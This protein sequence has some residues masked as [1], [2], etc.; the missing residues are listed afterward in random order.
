M[1][2]R[3]IHKSFGEKSKL[4]E[5]L[6]LNVQNYEK[7]QI[8]DWLKQ[9]KKIKLSNLGVEMS[10]LVA[11][12]F[13]AAQIAFHYKPRDTQQIAILLF[14]DSILFNGSG[15]LANISTGEGKSLVTISTAIAFIAL[16]GGNVDILTSSEIL[17]ERDAIESAK[18][19]NLFDISVSNN[20][21]WDASANE[22]VRKER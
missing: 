18:M 3:D 13:R 4:F 5:I 20:C 22:R 6:E 12:I 2:L 21:D 19:F 16:K 15:R 14:I 9:F 10:E 7:A 11:V 8:I 1:C 17:A